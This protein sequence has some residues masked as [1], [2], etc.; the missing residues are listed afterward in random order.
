[1]EEGRQT[2]VRVP[3]YYWRNLLKF[4]KINEC[5]LIIW[6]TLSFIDVYV[7]VWVYYMDINLI[8]SN[9]LWDRLL[10]LLYNHSEQSE[11][12]IAYS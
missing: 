3:N 5:P 11:K 9:E 10:K 12:I 6:Y 4:A 7:Y 1:M 8:V 2:C